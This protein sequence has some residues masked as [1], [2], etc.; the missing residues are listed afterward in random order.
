MVMRFFN[1]L[2]ARLRKFLNE[3]YWIEDYLK[4]GMKIGK[5][6]DINP[7]LVADYSHCWLI[8]IGNHV[9]LAPEVYLL[10]HDASTKR[11]LGFTKIGK[12]VIE[13]NAFIGARSIL[14][15]GVTI[16]KNSIVA[17]GSVVV[18]SVP[19]NTVV[20]GNPAKPIMTTHEFMDKHKITISQSICYDS[21]WLTQNGITQKMKLQMAEE[22]HD[23]PGYIV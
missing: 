22:L 12:L 1:F 4:A 8:E 6:C 23:K 19:P 5:N 2:R 13:D 17:A 10:A 18:K 20:G 3:E 15:P 14:L 11:E 9:T 16:G 21:S 7:G